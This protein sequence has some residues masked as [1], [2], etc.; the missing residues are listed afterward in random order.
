MSTVRLLSTKGRAQLIERFYFYDGEVPIENGIVEIPLDHPEWVQRA[1]IMGYRFDP[2]TEDVLTL[3]EALAGG[4]VASAPVEQSAESAGETDG[5]EDDTNTDEGSDA[6]G[7]PGVGDGLRESEPEGPL[8][9]D[10]GGDD[11][12]LGVGV[13]DGTEGDDSPGD[14]VSA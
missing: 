13:A 12:S 11:G 10:Q 9:D 3:D 1:Y 14:A 4:R 2:V 8:G 6:G 7:L 5:E